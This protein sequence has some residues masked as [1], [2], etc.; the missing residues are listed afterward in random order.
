ELQIPQKNNSTKL[1]DSMVHCAPGAG[2]DSLRWRE[3]YTYN[4]QGLCTE[5]LVQEFFPNSYWKNLRIIKYINYNNKGLCTEE[6]LQKFDNNDEPK[7]YHRYM[8]FYNNFAID[9]V[10]YQ[11]KASYTD[12]LINDKKTVYSYNRKKLL[13]K[14]SPFGWNWQKDPQSW[15][16]SP[17][18]V[19]YTY[20]TNGLLIE[21]FTRLYRY[22][23]TYNENNLLTEVLRQNIII[24]TDSFRNDSLCLYTYNEDGYAV[25]LEYKLWDKTDE[26]WV[27]DIKRTYEYSD[28]YLKITGTFFRWNSI[29]NTYKCFNMYVWE[30]DK[31]GNILKITSLNCEGEIGTYSVYY[32]SDFVGIK[33]DNI[34]VIYNVRVYPNPSNNQLKIETEDAIIKEIM[35]YDLTGKQIKHFNIN[36]SKTTLNIN[37]LSKGFYFFHIQTHQGVTVKRFV[38]E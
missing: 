21:K 20:N 37:D 33:Q 10:I 9:S 27:N 32:Y 22:T 19:M 7:D 18:E 6:L 38:K 35:I 16:A 31:D 23:H 24:T 3:I 2:D 30:Y 13:T 29:E 17:L 14:E 8:Y 15:E 26:K 11:R 25:E 34:A 5:M 4:A 36:D 12:T 1:L 28:D